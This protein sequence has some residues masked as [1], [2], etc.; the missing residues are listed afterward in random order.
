[1][2]FELLIAEEIDRVFS[3]HLA[4]P[5]VD[6]FARSGSFRIRLLFS[7]SSIAE[8]FLP[9]FV[10][11][12]PGEAD[13][14]IGFLTSAEADLSHLIP[15]KEAEYRTM[16]LDEVFAVWH[17]SE[18]PML[19]L[20]NRKANRA[21]IWLAAG[22]AP[23]WIASRPAL[24]IMYAF[25]VETPWIALHAGAV[26]RNGRSLLLIGNGRVGKTTA[27]LACARA[28]WD[29][30]GDDYVYVHT[31]SG[32]IEPLYCSARL[33]ADMGPAFSELLAA[34]AQ[35]SSSDG[36]PRYELRLSNE[37]GTERI[38][39]GFLAAILVPQRGGAML[40]TFSKARPRDLM[41]ALQ[42]SITLTQLGWLEPTI[43]KAITLI[44]LAPTYFV[45][46]GGEP[47]AIPAAFAE[48]LD[49]L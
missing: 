35:I 5:A 20:L 31:I 40:P 10:R 27:T 3:Q 46:T 6:A 11:D 7:R 22:A 34:P 17:P 18:L 23:D 8:E 13:L 24:P 12:D 42:T 16:A 33:R 26:S 41:P 25:S 48:F 30:A 43:N 1:M 9:S 2:S 38:K 15:D 45:D 32:K 44:G 14:E 37:L 47:A 28:G 4:S 49:G 39:G 29:Y 36:E 19:Y 21:L